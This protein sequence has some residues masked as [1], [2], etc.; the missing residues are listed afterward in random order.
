MRYT[1]HVSYS[2]FSVLFSSVTVNAALMGKGGSTKE[3]LKALTS[4]WLPQLK[5][6]TYYYYYTAW[7]LVKKT[8]LRLWLE[9]TERR[10][11][12]EGKE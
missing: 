12:S 9:Q 1:Q 7:S 2:V 11:E 5:L 3:P 8:L 10:T 4:R 6:V